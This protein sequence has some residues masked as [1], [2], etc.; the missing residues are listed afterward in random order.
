MMCLGHFRIKEICKQGGPQV[1]HTSGIRVPLYT[2]GEPDCHGH[3]HGI[4]GDPGGRQPS[5]CCLIYFP[6]AKIVS[7]SAVELG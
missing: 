1:G 5:R 2:S 6:V 7:H 4:G 3:G